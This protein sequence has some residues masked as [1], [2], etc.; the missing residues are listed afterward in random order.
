MID[1][2]AVT[3]SLK[4]D[5]GQ[6][7]GHNEDF[8]GSWEPQTEEERVAHGWLYIVADGVGGADAG[9]IAS[10]QA[11]EQTI[12]YYLES[13]ADNVSDRL[14]Q[15][16]QAA[17]DNLRQL[18]GDRARITNMATTLV[19]AVIQ[20]DHATFV[21]VGDS[22]GYYLHDGMLRQITKDQSL[23]AQLV[24]EGAIT[25]EEAINHPRR[26]VILS[27]L[28]PTREPKIELFSV[29][30]TDGDMIL[31]C[32]DGLTR[33]VTDEEIA[34]I[35]TSEMPN[36]AAQHLIE[37]ANE[38]GGTD[39]I[40]VAVVRLGES[41]ESAE[42]SLPGIETTTTAPRVIATLA[43]DLS[44]QHKPTNAFGLWTYTLFLGLIE[45]ILIFIVWYLLRV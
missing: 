26:N 23:V 24:E 30:I 18:T 17:N 35:I 39:N 10:Q 16:V 6:V 32:S 22:R 27:S 15:A 40:S 33:H 13:D 21:N 43:E 5:T 34:E 38:R 45:A 2:S 7:R 41:G 28:G 9:E 12:R 14:R 37:M 19:A 1:F 20:D 44:A 36:D 42:S 4:T 11:T 29:E 25:A 8:V 3:A 31:L